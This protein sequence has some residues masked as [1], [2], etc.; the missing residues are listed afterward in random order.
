[1]AVAV[2]TLPAFIMMLTSARISPHSSR[3]G[4]P[5]LVLHERLEEVFELLAR[6]VAL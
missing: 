1:M 5:A 3:L 6:T 4:E 2:A